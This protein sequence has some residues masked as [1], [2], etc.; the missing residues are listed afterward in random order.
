MSN[1]RRAHLQGGR[2]EPIF[3][4]TY[5]RQHL[6]HHEITRHLLNQAM[7]KTRP[8]YPFDTSR[9]DAQSCS[10]TKMNFK[11]LGEVCTR[12]KNNDDSFRTG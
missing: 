12:E 8:N 4:V 3:Y 5:R 9:L 11:M 6:F 2:E 7:A 10:E 1:Y